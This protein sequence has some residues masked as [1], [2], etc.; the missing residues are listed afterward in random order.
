MKLK[1]C[2]NLPEKFKQM[3]TEKHAKEQEI[4]DKKKLKTELRYKRDNLQ[5]DLKYIIMEMTETTNLPALYISELELR[6]KKT[7]DKLSEIKHKLKNL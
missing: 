4:K 5:C 3:L 1:M 2:D 7:S 6:Y